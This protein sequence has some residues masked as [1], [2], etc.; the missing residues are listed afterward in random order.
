MRQLTQTRAAPPV[1]GRTQRLTGAGIPAPGRASPPRPRSRA[2]LSR[3]SGPEHHPASGPVTFPQ[4][5][6]LTSARTPASCLR[7]A[8]CGPQPRETRWPGQP[9]QPR[10]TAPEQMIC[11][12][13]VVGLALPDA[14]PISAI[15]AD[16]A[17]RGPAHRVTPRN[18]P[19]EAASGC[20]GQTL[21]AVSTQTAS[22]AH[23]AACWVQVSPNS[24]A[25]TSIGLPRVISS[26][27][28]SSGAASPGG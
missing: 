26:R 19:K 23:E 4:R 5:S 10:Q 12:R 8:R 11:T 17:A 16:R 24:N 25:T 20:P 21:T 7:H 13:T 28:S 18:E 15:R 22:S 1:P 3:P 6:T 9:P 27:R 2:P 14:A